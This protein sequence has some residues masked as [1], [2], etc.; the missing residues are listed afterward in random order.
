MYKKIFFLLIAC[1]VYLQAFAEEPAKDYLYYINLYVEKN[2]SILA[3]QEKLNNAR[4]NK[5]SDAGS[6]LPQISVGHL[7]NYGTDD[8]LNEINWSSTLSA[9]QILFSGFSVLNT[10]L[11]SGH[12]E[13]VEEWTLAYKKLQAA[14]QGAALYFKCASLN[15]QAESLNEAVNLMKKRVDELKHREE[16]GKARISEVYSAQAKLAQL[17][18]QLIQTQLDFENALLEFENQCGEK[19]LSFI[20]PEVPLDSRASDLIVSDVIKNYPYVKVMEQQL[21]YYESIASARKGTFLPSISLLADYNLGASNYVSS[22]PTLKLM[23]NW[24]VFN[25]GSRL[26][27]TIAAEALVNKAK[28]ELEDV[29]KAI[30]TQIIEAMNNY[31]YSVLKLKELK[32]YY[33]FNFKNLKEQQKDYLLGNV[34]NLDVIQAMMDLKDSKIAYDNGKITAVQNEY[35]LKLYT[36]EQK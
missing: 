3:Q 17:K 36:G 19:P 7:R 21:H 11:M 6:F 25:G 12:L 34:N 13:G 29:K 22:G 26:A 4:W 23:A 16:L 33:D 5:I 2:Y 8:G 35:V 30:R 1:F 20:F 10:F 9:R 28:Y 15:F 24:D 14:E 32:T 27:D 18:S 31:N